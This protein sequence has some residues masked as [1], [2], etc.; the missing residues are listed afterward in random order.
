LVKIVAEF[1][2]PYSQYLDAEGNSVAPLPA[3]ADNHIELV[4]MYRM[5]VLARIFDTKAINLQRIGKLGTYPPA[6]G[7]EAVQVACGA[8]LKDEDSIAP[9][10][11]ARKCGVAF[12]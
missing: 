6:L 10:R 1:S 12:A 11:S 3:C 5:M 7:H 2:I 8:A 9:A 4:K